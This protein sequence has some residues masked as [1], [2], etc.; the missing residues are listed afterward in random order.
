MSLYPFIRGEIKL[1]LLKET[2]EPQIMHVIPLKSIKTLWKSCYLKL[3]K[4]CN[5]FRDEE[6]S[7]SQAPKESRG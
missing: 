6:C 5:G 3:I 7:V 1:K 4:Q 2:L